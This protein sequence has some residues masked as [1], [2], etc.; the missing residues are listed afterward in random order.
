MNLNDLT[1][2]EMQIIRSALGDYH[3]MKARFMAKSY[4]QEVRDLRDKIDHQIESR[5]SERGDQKRKK[6]A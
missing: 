5:L 1:M 3:S 6:V 2:R 4:P